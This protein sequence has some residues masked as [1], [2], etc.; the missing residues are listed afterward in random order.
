MSGVVRGV[1]KV[2]KKVAKVVK[3][4][5]PIVLAAAAIYFTAGAAMGAAGAAG[6]WGAAA[7]SLGT[8]IGGTGT[9]GSVLGGAITQAGY[10]AAIGGVMSKA[11][12]GSFSDGARAGAAVGAVTGGVGGYMN[13][14]QAAQGA[15]VQTQGVE[16]S[17]TGENAVLAPEYAKAQKGLMSQPNFANTGSG[18]AVQS[19]IQGNAAMT[20]PAPAVTQGGGLM[21]SAGNAL[22][23]VG[24]WVTKNQ[25]LVGSMVQGVGQGMGAE[26]EADALRRAERER[27]NR[28]ADSYAGASINPG[29]NYRSP[30][31]A[32][33]PAERFSPEYYSSYEFRYDPKQG[34]I[35]RAPVNS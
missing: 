5:A 28:I 2:F 26:A 30:D 12:G 20:T 31:R 27:Y 16:A 8:T 24:D 18:N 19:A 25:T 1:K 32:M 11:Q 21:N 33:S 3:R 29:I 13:A 17:L 10:G 23:K 7:S 4:V 34:R 6:G 22:S 35:V 15:T 14:G 9:L